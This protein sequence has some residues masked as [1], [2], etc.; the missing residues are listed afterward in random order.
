MNRGKDGLAAPKGKEGRKPRDQDGKGGLLAWESASVSFHRLA[1]PRAT[2]RLSGGNNGQQCRCVL[3]GCH[4][5][6]EQVSMHTKYTISVSQAFRSKMR[7]A[8]AS[9]TPSGCLVSSRPPKQG[10]R[11]AQLLR[12]RR[13]S[14]RNAALYLKS[15]T[16]IVLLTHTS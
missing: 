8:S 13:S 16:S 9:R 12:D 5:A 4:P 2:S 7:S 10:V 14:S 15:A 11:A 3:F 6:S 1:R